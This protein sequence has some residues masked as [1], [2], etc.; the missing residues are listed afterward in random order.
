MINND[1]DTSILYTDPLTMKTYPA[2]L[3][4]AVDNLLYKIRHKNI[5]EIC[6]FAIR[7]WERKNPTEAKK[8]YEAQEA[9]RNSRRSDTGSSKSKW[10]R[11][12]VNIPSDISYL[13]TKFADHKIEEYGRLKFWRDFAERYPGFAAANKI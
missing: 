12:T 2:W 7:V 8:F 9:F 6:D 4:E 1:I 13:L 3:V 5:W 10:I 11:G